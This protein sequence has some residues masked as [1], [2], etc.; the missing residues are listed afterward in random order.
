MPIVTIRIIGA[1]LI[2][3]GCGSYG[4]TIAANAGKEIYCLRNLIIAIEYMLCD[5]AYQSTALPELFKNASKA[6]KGII[7]RWLSLCAKVLDN[8]ASPSVSACMN[9]ALEHYK[10]MPPKT[11]KLIEAMG[12][13]MG[14]FDVD[15]QAQMLLSLRREAEQQLKLCEEGHVVRSRSCKTLAICAGAAIVILLI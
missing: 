1:V 10:D 6:T 3:L 2:L 9:T 15:G 12:K 14:H 7:N 4:F 5:I 8:R 13:R 11:R